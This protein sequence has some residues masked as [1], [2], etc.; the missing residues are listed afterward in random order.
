MATTFE[1]NIKSYF[2]ECYRENMTFLFDLWSADDVQTNWQAIYDSVKSERM[3]ITGCP[4][5]VWDDAR[6]QQ[7]LTDFN[8]W[9]NDGYQP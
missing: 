6:R 9:K 8:N 3:P 2:S 7:F 5:G 4:E 1:T